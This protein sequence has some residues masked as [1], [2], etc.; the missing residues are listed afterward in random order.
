MDIFDLLRADGYITVNKTLAHEIGLNETIIYSELVSLHQYWRKQ[1]K[2]TDDNW[3][4]CTIENLERNTTLTR[5]KQDR[6]IKKL[7]ELGL[8]E[9]ERRGLPAKRYFKI[10][11]KIY[12][13]ILTKARDNQN[14][15]FEQTSLMDTYNK[16]S[17][18]QTGN[19]NLINKNKLNNK[20]IN[21]N[22]NSDMFEHF[23]RF[24]ES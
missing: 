11:N 15:D 13:L 5:N 14:V 10:T 20:D 3:F 22:K 4:F 8:I 7:Q 1:G 17:R 9:V 12:E 2:L 19:K 23:K 6:A 24:I 18:N 16:D 21:I